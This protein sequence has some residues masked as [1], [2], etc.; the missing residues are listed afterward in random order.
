MKSKMSFFKIGII[1]QD[2][3]QHGWIGI[4]YLIGLLFALPLQL[5]MLASNQYITQ[6]RYIDNVYFYNFGFQAILLFILPV[7][8]GVFLFRYIQTKESADMIHSLP[9]RRESLYF[10]HLVSGFFMLLPAVWITG[11]TTW[12]LS[13]FVPFSEQFKTSDF[14][15]WLGIMTLFTI[16]FFIFSSFVG[17]MTGMSVAQGI[18]TYIFLFLPTGIMG[19]INYHLSLYLYGFPE[20]YMTSAKIE[21][22]SP[23]IR[24]ISSENRPF[25]F[26]ETVI[27]LVLI[28]IF[29][30][31]GYLLYKYRH[32]E[33]A[34]QAISF[35]LLRPIFKYGVTFS[36]MLMVGMYFASTQS[37]DQRWTIF[38][39][40]IG[41]IIGFFVAE[42]VL[43]K[44]WRVFVKRTF[45]ELLIYSIAATI[46]FTGIQ[47]DVTR[48]EIRLPSPEEVEGVY[49][50]NAGFELR[51][52]LQRNEDIFYQDPLFVEQVRSLH[53]E[54]LTKKPENL[55]G[56]PNINY[57]VSRQ[58]VFAYQLKNGD[59]MVR[60]YTIPVESIK[61]ALKP[62]I[63]SPHYKKEHYLLNQLDQPIDK[64]RF[65]SSFTGRNLTITNPDEINELKEIL[66]QEI[67]NMKYED[68]IDTRSSW[69]TIEFS[70]SNPKIVLT[71]T[72]IQY[73]NKFFSFEWNKS[74]VQLEKWLD[75]KGYLSKARIQSDDLQYLEIAKANETL[76]EGEESINYPEEIFLKNPKNLQFIRVEDKQS[77]QEALIQYS[78]YGKAA[79]YVKFKT[80][81]GEEFYGLFTKDN[82]PKF[83]AQLF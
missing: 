71:P 4:I 60:E 63:E 13:Y 73:D 65:M 62:V 64:V 29:A 57:T 67:L 32:L 49:F 8:T 42:I 21:D 16:F 14:F 69:A 25:S 37:R 83:V 50:G 77:I 81:K 75:E 7:L 76:E 23:I 48:Y 72:G 68:M 79:Y 38:G 58:M 74:F 9:I 6:Y 26:G 36:V 43:Q 11:I 53:Q 33:T 15:Q 27:Y 35:K 56:K 28:L 46:L 2:F 12:F 70:F 17:I 1:K 30:V 18:L 78:S 52:K 20:N 41:S 3:R 40:I 19:L 66:K 47:M 5:M 22:W 51:D 55:R 24:I 54:I 45:V 82:V 59:L 80:I 44:T 34:T 10:N 31:S 61:E 39:Y